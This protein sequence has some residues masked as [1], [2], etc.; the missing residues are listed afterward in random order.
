MRSIFHLECNLNVKKVF[1]LA[2]YFYVY[3]LVCLLLIIGVVY[4]DYNSS[5]LYALKSYIRTEGEVLFG[6]VNMFTTDGIESISEQMHTHVGEWTEYDISSLLSEES[7]VIKYDDNDEVF[8]RLTKEA[9]SQRNVSSYTRYYILY[10][11]SINLLYTAN[12]D[13]QLA[14]AYRRMC[15]YQTGI[16]NTPR[17]FLYDNMDVIQ[18]V[19]SF[20]FTW[21][22]L[23]SILTSIYV[24]ANS[25]KR[26][27]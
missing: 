7:A 16:V 2:K 6:D 22:S 9:L 8:E 10:R 11:A 27:Q 20:C 4:F 23:V 25:R 5:D 15:M 1:K 26:R 14:D 12:S 18:G 17:L 19:L 21:F 3:S 13:A 24:L